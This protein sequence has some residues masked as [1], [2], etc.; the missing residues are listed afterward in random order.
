MQGE[1]TPEQ[2][3]ARLE[4]LLAAAEALLTKPKWLKFSTLMRCLKDAPGRGEDIVS[5]VQQQKQEVLAL[6]K[7]HN[8]QVQ[9]HFIELMELGFPQILQIEPVAS[10]CAAVAK[11]EFHE[12]LTEVA[13]TAQA[14]AQLILPAHTDTEPVHTVKEELS[15]SPTAAREDA[16]EDSARPRR[17]AAV[18]AR[19]VMSE[20]GGSDDSWTILQSSATSSCAHHEVGS[21]SVILLC[22]GSACCTSGV[23]GLQRATQLQSRSSLCSCGPIS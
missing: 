22:S 11:L 12:Q 23:S 21:T 1:E 4:A 16:I 2:V 15:E 19:F 6:L 3:A 18:L 7:G 20:L 10:S 14:D 9:L 13:H 17:T 8:K 5:F